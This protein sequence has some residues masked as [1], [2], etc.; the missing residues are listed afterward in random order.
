MMKRER[1]G[2]RAAGDGALYKRADGMWVGTIEL[3][4]GADGKRKRKTVSSKDKTT[5]LQKLRKLRRQVED[6]MT[7]PVSNRETVSGWMETWLEEFARP[8]IGP[9]TLQT[10]RSAVKQNIDPNIGD[11]KLAKLT[12]ADVRSVQRKIIAAGKS[13]RTAEAAHRIL[14]KAL[15][16]A[17]REGLISSSPGE[18]TAGPQVLSQERPA[19][20]TDE[21]RVMLESAAAHEDEL[22]TRFAAALLTGAR[23]GELTGL[24]WDRVDLDAGTLD[25]SWQLQQIKLHPGADPDDPHR[26]DVEP[27]FEH[28]PIWR[29]LALKR[30]KMQK[31]EKRGR[32]IPLP[33]PLAL[34]LI[35][36]KE[37]QPPNPWDLVWVRSG[38]RPINAKEDGA[39]WK[40]ALKRAGVK[41]VDLYSARH[42]TATLLL[43][44]GVDP[45][46][47]QQILGHSNVVTT[48]GYQHVRMDLARGALQNL[49]HLLGVREDSESEQ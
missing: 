48:R 32:R 8:Q 39:A 3:P 29:G 15:N 13:T 33:E 17:V 27:G 7:A 46:I 45:H 44:A 49:H 24:Q 2:R 4:A 31:G 1:M 40:R 19:L 12:P 5:A 47:V 16:D 11:K 36:H 30:P 42:T 21:A 10:Y 34:L 23:P 26:F 37:T 9:R 41:T 22:V 38:P 20:T 18:H 35:E 6:G 28:I 25:L 14:V 43:E